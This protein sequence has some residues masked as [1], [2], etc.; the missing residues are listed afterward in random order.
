LQ[1]PAVNV[2][3]NTAESNV[4]VVA[5]AGDTLVG[6]AAMIEISGSLVSVTTVH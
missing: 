2:F 3:W 4:I 6:G 5:V 1:A